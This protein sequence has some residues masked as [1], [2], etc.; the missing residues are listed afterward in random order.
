MNRLDGWV[1]HPGGT[2]SPEAAHL[3]GITARGQE[4]A[5]H[6]G[7]DGGPS[8][9]GG[10]RAVKQKRRAGHMHMAKTTASLNKHRREFIR[11]FY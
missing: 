5:A 3:K 1:R 9:I 2:W 4:S 6:S 10:L 11:A 7:P 8:T